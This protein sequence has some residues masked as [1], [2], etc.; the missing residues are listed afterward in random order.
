MLDFFAGVR[1]KEEATLLNFFEN[2][3]NLKAIHDLLQ[4]KERNSQ[5]NS[6]PFYIR[7][8]YL[9]LR[10][11]LFGDI[12]RLCRSVAGDLGFSDGAIEF[13]MANDNDC[14]SFSIAG[15][16]HAPHIIVLNRGLVERAAPDE[17]KFCVGHE[18]G[19]LI[20]DHSY[21]SKTIQFIYPASDQQPPLFQKLYD[22]WSKISEISADRMGL[23]A[24]RDIDASL[25]ALF[26]LSSGLDNGHFD[27]DLT[28]LV[29]IAESAFE[30]MRRNPSYVFASH[31]ANP[32]RIIALKRFYESGLWRSV[33]SG[34]EPAEDADFERSMGEVLA[35][36]KRSP[37][38]ELEALELSF[39]ASAGMFLMIADQDIDD[40]EYTLL[41]NTLSRYIH[42]PPEYLDHMDKTGM[43][44]TM[45]EAAD[46]IVSRYPWRSKDLL[47]KLFHVINR[48]NKIK[49]NELSMFMNIGTEALRLQAQ[50]VVDI[51]LEGMRNHYKP[52]S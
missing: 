23:L 16:G 2:T 51:V 11:G 31:P 13:Y 6:V 46:T 45:R 15:N 28:K 32:V 35:I 27:L 7:G 49:D 4:I 41:V 48:D 22:A 8:Y 24:N 33:T 26:R 1:E 30:E 5:E 19:H 42:W 36:I 21:V 14:N 12:P 44:R 47:V 17:L 3:F 39:M 37:L 25:R 10:D 9:P 20:F 38:N 34:Q 18:M 52:L 50:T 43:D 29:G 40:N